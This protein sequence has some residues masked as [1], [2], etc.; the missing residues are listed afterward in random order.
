[1][2]IKQ[3][4][5]LV[6]GGSGLVGYALKWGGAYG[7]ALPNAVYVSSKDY[8][9]RDPS[10]AREMFIKHRPKFV[11][12]LAAKVGGVKANSLYPGDFYYDN[13][14]I[15]TNVLNCAKDFKVE[16]LISLLSTCIYPN[17]VK[18]PIKAQYLHDGPPHSSNAPYAYAKRMLDVQSQAYKKQFNCNFTTVVL[19][20]LFGENDNFHYEDSHVI[21][22][23]IRK[24]YEAKKNNSQPT[25][26][27]D[28][29]PLREFTYSGDLAEI[30]LFIFKNYDSGLPLN[31]GRG[32]EYSLKEV[33]ELIC[34]F[35]D[36]D[37][38]AIHWDTSQ[39]KG[40]FRKPSDN[41]PLL[42]LGWKEGDYTDF[43]NALEKTCGW[44]KAN[45]PNIRGIN[46]YT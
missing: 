15:N 1:M 12:H 39:P 32:I 26:W 5:I 16:K 35:L 9:L 30:L 21:P 36:Y 43:S 11:I 8:D 13:I 6:T 23:M 46:T 38:R 7:N 27:G 28:G 24:I 19:N 42:K 4:D 18:Y 45:Y 34:E 25:L 22:A 40:Q 2:G 31:I 33:A 29:S 14:M 10:Q 17:D 44:F 3:K 37:F 20:N 41:S